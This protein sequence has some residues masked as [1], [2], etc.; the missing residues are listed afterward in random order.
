MRESNIANKR[1]GEKN[2]CTFI[3]MKSSV[4]AYPVELILVVLFQIKELRL[5]NTQ[6]CTDSKTVLF[7]SE[8][9]ND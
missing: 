1:N 7:Q 2:I 5:T 9:Q 4:S 3:E 6:T 8:F